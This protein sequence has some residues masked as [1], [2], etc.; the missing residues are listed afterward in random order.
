MKNL[1]VHVITNPKRQDSDQDH[2]DR[3]VARHPGG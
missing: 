3:Q 2:A 1:T